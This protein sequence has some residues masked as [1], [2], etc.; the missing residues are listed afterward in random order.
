V[1]AHGNPALRQ[2]TVIHPS[3]PP[4]RNKIPTTTTTTTP[5]P[6]EKDGMNHFTLDHSYML[7][8]H[9]NQQATNQNDRFQFPTPPY[10]NA[11]AEKMTVLMKTTHPPYI[12]AILKNCLK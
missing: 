1:P 11:K 2:R 7:L 3:N 9:A 10:V 8:L 6:E 4:A 5:P 12:P